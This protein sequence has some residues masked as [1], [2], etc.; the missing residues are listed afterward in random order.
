MQPLQRP[1]VYKPFV[2]ASMPLPFASANLAVSF[3]VAATATS[4]APG[5]R[6]GVDKSVVTQLAAVVWKSSAA[7]V[8]R[9]IFESDLRP[10]VPLQLSSSAASAV[11]RSIFALR[12]RQFSG[13]SWSPLES[14]TEREAR[15][16]RKG[17]KDNY[18][19]ARLPAFQ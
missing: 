15:R 17:G 2:R 11:L 19:D 7:R 9:E 12:R 13:R 3:S 14:A 4:S 16:Q 18:R 5:I 8:L 10:I 1:L 6:P